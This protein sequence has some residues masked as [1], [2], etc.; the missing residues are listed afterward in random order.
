VLG[1]GGKAL[2]AAGEKLTLGTGTPLFKLQNWIDYGTGVRC[3]PLV[4]HSCMHPLTCCTAAG[5]APVAISL[6]GV[7]RL[8]IFGSAVNTSTGGFNVMSNGK[9]IGVTSN[10]VDAMYHVIEAVD[11]A[12]NTTFYLYNGRLM[13]NVTQGNKVLK[14]TIVLSP[15]NE[16][17][18]LPS[19]TDL[20]KPGWSFAIPVAQGKFSESSCSLNR[21][22]QQHHVHHG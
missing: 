7:G 15:S 11:T 9:K 12:A 4:L 13:A 21:W 8:V 6:I 5:D 20:T 16:V 2:S 10:K 22:H 19:G 18:A 3:S 14:Y 1:Q 17:R